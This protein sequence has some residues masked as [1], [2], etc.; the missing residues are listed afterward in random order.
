MYRP[1]A[2]SWLLPAVIACVSSMSLAQTTAP[3]ADAAMS[4]Q[5]MLERMQDLQSQ[6][7]DLRNRLDQVQPTTQPAAT[8]QV[9]P[10][11][12]NKVHQPPILN[13]GYSLDKGFYIRTDDGRF[14]LHPWVFLQARDAYTYRSI[15]TSN[16]H[17]GE[18]GLELPRA[19]FIVDGNA[20]S[21][22]L[23]Y[24]FIWATSDQTGNL[25]LQDAWGRYHIPGTP[26]AVEGGNIRDPVDHEQ[27]LFATRTLTPERSLVNNVLLNGDDIVKGA[28]L[29]AG[30]DTPSSL[31]GEVA[32]TSGER[33]FD[34]TFQTYPT[35]PASWGVAGRVEWKLMGDFKDYDQ[36]TSLD[37]KEA[38]LV[39]GG[40]ADYTEGG[41]T[42]GLTH[43]L[44]AQYN[45]PCGLSLYAA[46]LGRYVRH[47]AGNPA[48]DG[49]PASTA[50][51]FA[52]ADTY[53]AT[54]RFMAAYLIQDRFEPFVRYEYLHL[55][56]REFTAPTNN[57]ISDITVG[58]NYYFYGHRAKAT[59]GASYLPQGSPF[60]STLGDVLTTHRGQDFVIQ[61]QVQLIF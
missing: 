35:N 54:A 25:G 3:S 57:D 4:Q 36:F 17:D 9:E 56:S 48:T 5:Q 23:T 18:N 49:T 26:L 44:D 19:K 29:A 41:S 45:L 13:A 24:Q 31:R 7:K 38:L 42:A 20:F 8:A 14:L 10:P 55:D 32:F 53:D 33:N 6:V 1:A 16:V 40:G 27:I 15:D 47:D 28:E 34:T 61:S 11:V 52:S 59:F 51:V 50:A 37:D 43:V 39:I 60:A 30:Y 2:W 21:P 58:F 22:D 12:Q 46:Y